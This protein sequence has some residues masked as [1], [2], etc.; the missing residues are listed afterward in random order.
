MN[1]DCV[2]FVYI[3]VYVVESYEVLGDFVIEVWC[4][5]VKNICGVC[6]KIIIM[7]NEFDL[8]GVWLCVCLMLEF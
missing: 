8:V 1:F 3:D 4:K 5:V 7:V 2:D 6:V